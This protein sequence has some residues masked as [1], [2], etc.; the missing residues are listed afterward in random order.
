MIGC[1]RIASKS[2]VGA[3]VE[4]SHWEP[5]RRIHRFAPGGRGLPLASPAALSVVPIPKGLIICDEQKPILLPEEPIVTLRFDSCELRLQD[6]VR[7]CRYEQYDSLDI[8]F[9]QVFGSPRVKR[10]DGLRSTAQRASASWDQSGGRFNVRTSRAYQ[11]A[12]E[13][14]VR[15]SRSRRSVRSPWQI[16]R[17]TNCFSAAR[18]RIT[19]PR[20]CTS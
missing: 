14:P 15:H 18:A 10:L 11:G 9:F 8:P 7:F 13:G 20:T 12:A 19:I 4:F 5:Q 2:F 6:Q 3:R 1:W 16:H 17:F